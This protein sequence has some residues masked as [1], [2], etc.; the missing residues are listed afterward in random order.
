[1]VALTLQAIQAENKRSEAP[2]ENPTETPTSTAHPAEETLPTQTFTLTTQPEAATTKAT[3]PAQNTSAPPSVTAPPSEAAPSPAS[4]SAQH[5]EAVVIQ[6]PGPASKV[7]SPLRI[8]AQVQAEP[9]AQV[10][11]EILGED[12]RLLAREIKLIRGIYKAGFASLQMDLEFEISA[13]AEAGRLKISVDD[14]LGRTTALNSIPLVL[15]SL[16]D[17]DILIPGSQGSAILVDQPGPQAQAQGGKLAVTG[18]ARLAKGQ[19]MMARL[20]SPEGS[21]LGA[22][23]VG[24]SQGEEGEYAPFAVEIPYRVAEPIE[25]LLVVWAGGSS[26]QDI[27]YLTSLEVTL[28]P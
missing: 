9:G 8:Q 22:R 17:A 28:A 26:L 16:G 24:F 23:L 27:I 11:V 3:T 19:P 18:L 12:G 20:V 1:M 7:V 15:L 13:P 6:I 2:D 14:P 4:P 5:E 10:R 25:A 21:E